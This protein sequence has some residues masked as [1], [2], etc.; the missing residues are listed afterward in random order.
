[1]EALKEK[2]KG[3]VTLDNV[4]DIANKSKTKGTAGDG[5][6]RM[7]DQEESD[8]EEEQDQ[9]EAEAEVDE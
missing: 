1:M 2:D 3:R 4:F 6:R 9:E 8:E 7:L 5:K